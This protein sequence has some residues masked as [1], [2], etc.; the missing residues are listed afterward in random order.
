MSKEQKDELVKIK[1]LKECPDNTDRT[2]RFEEGQEIEVSKERADA[3]IAK[4]LAE[5]VEEGI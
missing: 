1:V 2:K 3:A 4:G 5:L